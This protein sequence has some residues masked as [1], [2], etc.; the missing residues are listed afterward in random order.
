[1]DVVVRPERGEFPFI[2]CESKLHN[3]GSAPVTILSHV[4]MNLPLWVDRFVVYSRTQRSWE[5]MAVREM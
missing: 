1:M 5:V 4:F 3:L 2:S